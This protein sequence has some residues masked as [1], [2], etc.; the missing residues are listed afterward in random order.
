MYCC[1]HLLVSIAVVCVN[2]VLD[3]K[4]LWLV[5]FN[6]NSQSNFYCEQVDALIRWLCVHRLRRVFAMHSPVKYSNM[7]QGRNVITSV[8]HALTLCQNDA[9]YITKSSLTNNLRILALRIILHVSSSTN[10]TGFTSSDGV[11]WERGRKNLQFSPNKSLYL[12]N[13]TKVTTVANLGACLRICLYIGWHDRS[14][15]TLNG[16]LTMLKLSNNY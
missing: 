15:T 8:C 3:K 16:K 9:S 4:K 1:W 10:S 12:R 14:W 6:L 11:K 7:C 13:G 2:C 5:F